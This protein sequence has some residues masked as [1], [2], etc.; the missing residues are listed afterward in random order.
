MKTGPGIQP[1]VLSW[2]HQAHRAQ[3]GIASSLIFFF[4]WMQLAPAAA[5][6]KN[7]VQ[8][9][10]SPKIQATVQASTNKDLQELL[11]ERLDAV[12]KKADRAKA[13]KH[14][15][16][17]AVERK[18][19]KELQTRLRD[20]DQKTLAGFQAD[21]EHIRQFKLPDVIQ[22]RHDAALKRFEDETANLQTQLAALQTADDAALPTLAGK[23]RTHLE[24][25]KPKHVRAFDPKRLP[26]HVADGKVR[27]PFTTRKE[28]QELLNPHVKISSAALPAEQRRETITSAQLARIAYA[29]EHGEHYSP[30]P[31]AVDVASIGTMAGLTTAATLSPPTASD[32]APTEDV[33]ITPAIQALADRL[34][35]NPVQIYNW[36]HDN[37]EFIPSYG[38]I[39]GSDL[40]LQTLQGNAFDISSLL[41]AL[42]RASGVPARYNYG[43]I[44]IPAATAVNWVGGVDSPAQAQ[45]LLSEGG[46]PNTGLVS[47]G[48]IV[49]L[50][51][52]HVW[53]DAWVASSPSRGT[54][55]QGVFTW[56]PL[57]ASYK[58]H[59]FS[60]GANI[61]TNVPFDAQSFNATALTGSTTDSA[62]GAISNINATGISDYLDT[63]AATA[64]AYV[65]QNY[66]PSPTVA[67]GLGQTT[68]V[69]SGADV[70][71]SAVPY[72]VVANGSSVSSLSDAQR[73]LLN[74][75]LFLDATDRELDSPAFEH[76][77]SLPGLGAHRLG[78]TFLPATP[79]DAAALQSYTSQDIGQ[80]PAY[81]INVYPALQIDGQTVASGPAM[82]LGTSTIWSATLTDPQGVNSGNADFQRS[83]GDELVFG[84]DGNGITQSLIQSRMAADGGSFSASEDLFLVGLHYWMLHDAQDQL[85]A[86]SYQVHQMRMPSVGVFASPLLVNYKFGIAWSGSYKSRQMDVKRNL[87]AAV[88]SDPTRIAHFV[89][90]SGMS[91]SRVEGATFDMLF[92]H[93]LG[94]SLS[95]ITAL[96][97]ANSLG[98]PIVKIDSS[99][100][101][102]VLPTL[103]IDGDVSQDVQDAV[104][105]GNVVYVPA[106]EFSYGSWAGTGYIVLNPA[107]GEGAYQI[108]GGLSGGDELPC[109]NDGHTQPVTVV[110][111]SIAYDVNFWLLVGA[112]A[113]AAAIVILTDG[114]GAPAAAAIVGVAIGIGSTGN[115]QAATLPGPQQT[116]WDAIFG[117]TY[118][119][120][121]SGGPYPGDGIPP[122][123]DCSATQL[124]ALQAAKDQACSLPSKCTGADID[125]A[126]MATKVQNRLDCISARLA[127]MNTCFRGGDETHWGQIEQQLN[128]L[129][130][131]VERMAKVGCP[132]PVL[133]P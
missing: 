125:C 93:E 118:G 115:A 51:L 19:L 74:L 80:I 34:N 103:S 108:S 47:G 88:A 6:I 121:R 44:Q 30:K 109:D 69:P 92:G 131:C 70:I 21:E 52:E 3:R 24:T 1:S 60:Q 23:L 35:H 130:C 5:A 53:V 42:L 107:T 112:I 62:T 46:I 9:P 100:I 84:I 10:A 133:A 32:L 122:P 7:E 68:I 31:D 59:Q 72:H 106:A 61:Q 110:V 49:A 85:I 66:G 36:V 75:D 48:Q 27:K 50:Q 111:P 99:N 114:V 89:M 128:G 2:L 117:N 73:Y 71:P 76:K 86:N 16:D 113:L 126:V 123:G 105:V 91:G 120:W 63:Y 57:D 26:F 28:L 41:I 13:K 129:A 65:Y 124:A 101:D 40:T 29:S 25:L 14:T 82:T 67:N 98:I 20:D 104:A 116:L 97:I 22:Q 43:T 56:M 58:L 33:Q 79:S 96:S 77:L 37:I 15:V 38:S 119:P 95:T 64:T 87:I 8:H 132:A 39:Q 78:V 54:K 12:V 45:Q 127:V 18:S 102:N 81:L 94:S 4:S 11:S 55:T 83:A 90:Q 17:Y